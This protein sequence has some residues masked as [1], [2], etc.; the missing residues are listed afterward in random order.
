M[1]A[2]IVRRALLQ[3]AYSAACVLWSYGISH[4]VPADA[5]S[6]LQGEFFATQNIWRLDRDWFWAGN[7]ETFDQP[8]T[9]T[10]SFTNVTGLRFS[11]I[12]PTSY[13]LRF[14][15]NFPE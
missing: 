15:G 3:A 1:V 10:H 8:W 7:L 5:R 2:R 13:D 6:L 9:D 11:V 12:S 14:R 4:A